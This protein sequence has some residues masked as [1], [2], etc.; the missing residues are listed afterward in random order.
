MQALLQLRQRFFNFYKL[1]EYFRGDVCVVY[2]PVVVE[3]YSEF[4]RNRIQ[5]IVG[6]K[7]K[8]LRERQSVYYSPFEHI[9]HACAIIVDEF[10][11]EPRGVV[12]YEDTAVAKLE[13]SGMTFSYGGAGATISS[14]MPVSDIISSDSLRLGF[15]NVENCSHIA[16]SIILK[17]ADFDNSVHIARRRR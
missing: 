6:E 10:E 16:P 11:V 17:G 3:G 12:S 15:I 5:F 4:V 8:L 9:A 14:V 1:Q 7:Q 13:K 2:R